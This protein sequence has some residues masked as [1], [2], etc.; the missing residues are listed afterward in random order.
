YTEAAAA[1]PKFKAAAVDE[2]RRRTQAPGFDPATRFFADEGG[3][4][5]GYAAFSP[6]GRVSY[7]WCRKGHE[8]LAEPLFQAALDAMRRR[9]LRKAF[10][11]YRGDWPAALEFF[12][13]H[14]FAQAREMVN[15]VI[16]VVDMPTPPAPPDSAIT[17]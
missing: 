4:P 7:P 10:A 12:R 14:D 9:G 15:F 11:G 6:N 2:V 3:G 5:A 8:H 17:P 13:G 16:D 1:L